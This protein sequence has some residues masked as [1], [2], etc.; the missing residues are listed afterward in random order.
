MSFFITNVSERIKCTD[1]LYLAVAAVLRRH[2]TSSS[3]LHSVT[4]FQPSLISLSINSRLP[5]NSDYG[6]ALLI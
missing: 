4:F 2:I 5:I 3:F 1:G 6:V